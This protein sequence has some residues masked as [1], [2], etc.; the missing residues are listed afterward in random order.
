MSSY[1][2]S[3]QVVS[4][5]FF[6]TKR[7]GSHRMII[8]LKSLNQH[9]QKI[10]FKMDTLKNAIALM[11]QVCLLLLFASIGLQDVS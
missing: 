4:N 8:N 10:Y 3:E 1:P 9:M 6:T 11:K 7:D 5:V 2:C